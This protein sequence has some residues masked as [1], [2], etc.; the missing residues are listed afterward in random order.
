M[1]HAAEWWAKRV[2]EVEGGAS[3]REIAE[4]HGV[5][6]TTLKWWRG[7]FGRRARRKAEPSPRMLPV[8]LSAG[9]TQT[10]DDAGA[11]EVIVE[12]KR[13]RMT[14]RGALTLGQWQVLVKSALR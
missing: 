2:A 5:R 13:L 9:R 12:G 4:R 11:F 1:A 10:V 7:E 14:V 8:V 6:V 3:L